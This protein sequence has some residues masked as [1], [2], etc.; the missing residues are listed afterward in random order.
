[1]S[2]VISIALWAAAALTISA[3]L[4]GIAVAVNRRSRVIDLEKN[5]IDTTELRRWL[6]DFEIALQR[7][8]DEGWPAEENHIK[9]PRR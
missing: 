1:M 2:A 7:R 6:V 5:E 3:M 4:V 8:L 9:G